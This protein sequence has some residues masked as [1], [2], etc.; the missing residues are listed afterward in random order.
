M[1]AAICTS[2]WQNRG[3]GFC[4]SGKSEVK[5]VIFTYTRPVIRRPPEP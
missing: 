4:K 1:S 3:F 5:T 2:W